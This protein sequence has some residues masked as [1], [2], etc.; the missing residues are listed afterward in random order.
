MTH[1]PHGATSLERRL[2]L[3]AFGV[4]PLLIATTLVLMAGTER[5]RPDGGWGPARLLFGA[6]CIAVVAVVWFVVGERAFDHRRTGIVCFVIVSTSLIVGMAVVPL[7][8]ITQALLFPYLWYTLDDTRRSILGSAIVCLLMAFALAAQDW[9]GSFLFQL[10]IEIVSFT[11]SLVL[12]LTIT[13]SYETSARHEHLIEQLRSTRADLAELSR[14]AGATA[15]RERL[16]RELHDT[17]AQSLAGLSMLAEKSARELRRT[18]GLLGPGRPDVRDAI[19]AEAARVE[20]I[21]DLSRDSLAEIRAIIAESAPVTDHLAT[22]EAALDRLVDRFRLETGIESR[23]VV[24][25]GDQ[26]LSRETEVVLLRCVQ[27]GLA[28]VRRHS[29]ASAAR[30]HVSTVAGH[31]VLRLEDD[32]RGFDPATAPTT[33][34]GLPGLRERARTVGGSVDIVSAPGT[35]TRVVVRLPLEELGDEP[36]PSAVPPPITFHHPSTDGK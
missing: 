24:D 36:G 1:E 7:L 10:L 29:G 26:G 33:G 15:E 2:W 6:A 31:A 19:D 11:I 23:V 12:G 4:V 35:G 14:V 22:F 20:R 8:G 30:L 28:N 5:L 16:S 9:P 3:L 18:S 21:T 34:F 25:L 32:G 27:E 13:R 17:L